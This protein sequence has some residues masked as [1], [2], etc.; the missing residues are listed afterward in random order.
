M[1]L[2]SLITALALS[3]VCAISSAQ[4]RHSSW[5]YE[6]PTPQYPVHLYGKTIDGVYCQIIVMSDPT[7]ITLSSYDTH[8]DN[9]ELLMIDRDGSR[10]GKRNETTLA[11]EMLKI[12]TQRTDGL[13]ED[14]IHA[15]KKAI[16]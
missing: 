8:F 14:I 4:E 7:T 6:E 2:S 5:H 10:T 1:N 12:C 3:C 15:V 13:P 11:R 16:P 9:S